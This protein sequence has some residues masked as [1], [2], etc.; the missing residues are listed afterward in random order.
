MV[1]NRQMRRYGLS[2]LLLLTA[3][4]KSDP[5]VKAL[6]GATLL[7]GAGQTV[8][9]AVVIVSGND[10]QA[11]GPRA[12]VPIPRDASELKLS[13]KFIVPGL[14]D[15]R[16]TLSPEAAKADDELGAFLKAGITSVG[17]ANGGPPPVRTSPRVLPASAQAAGFADA[18][19]SSGGRS[20]EDTFRK[21]D[22]M[23]KAEIAASTILTSATKNGAA[24]LQQARLGV[25]SAG[26][27]ADLLVLS[28]DPLRDIA[29]L[30]KIDRVM[31]DGHWIK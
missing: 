18:V 25:L 26:H 3:C 9:D 28:A 11:A 8:A 31:V 15:V 7:D 27:K 1:N 10:I 13:G 19:I 14:I 29:N 12:S 23:A 4:G 20:P 30:R 5:P 2:V 16:I 17:V 22:R 21:I 6:T 24:W